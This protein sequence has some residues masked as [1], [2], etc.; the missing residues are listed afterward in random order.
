MKPK[1]L[2]EIANA[3]GRALK[4]SEIQAIEDG[5]QRHLNIVARKDVDA[6][7]KMSLHER[8]TEAAKSASEEVIANAER[9]AEN[10][11]RQIIALQRNLKIM[12]D[13]ANGQAKSKGLARLLTQV[14]TDIKGIGRDY[15][16]QMMD[17]INAAEPK[18]FEL[19]ENKAAVR[20]FLQELD[21]IKTGNEVAAKGAKAWSATAE[22]MRERFNR[23]GGDIGKLFGWKVPQPHDQARILK[24][25][26]TKWVDD[27][28][29]WLNRERYR[30]NAGRQLSDVELRQA[31]TEM[32]ETL[33][34]GGKNNMEPGQS[35]QS[36]LANRNAEHREI[37]FKDAD[38]YIA[39]MQDYGKGSIFEAMQRHVNKMARD[40]GLIEAMGPNSDRTFETLNDVTI[41]EEGKLSKTGILAVSND[42]RYKALSNFYAQA[43][44]VKLADIGS[45]IRN[46][47]SATKLQGNLLSSFADIPT[48]LM[49]AHYNNLPMAKLLLSAL[50]DMVH[51]DT[52]KLEFANRVGLVTDSVIADMNRFSGDNLAQGWTGKLANVTQK[53]SFMNRWTDSL[54]RAFSVAYMGALGKMTRGDYSALDKSD[55][56]I[57]AQHGIDEATFNV[58]KAAT[59]ENWRGSQ[60]LTPDSIRAI[61][62]VGKAE[63]DRAVTKLLGMIVDEADYAVISPDLDTRARVQSTGQRGTFNGEL[64]RAFYLFKSFPMAMASRQLTRIM[65]MDDGMAKLGYSASLIAGLTLFGAL[66]IQ[67]KDLVSGKNPRDMTGANGRNLPMLGKFWAAAFAQGGGAGI[68]GDILYTGAGGNARGGQPNWTNLAGP[69]IGTA[70][71]TANVT[72]GNVGQALG[73]QKTN[74]GAEAV[75]LAR[76][77]APFL[78]LWYAR[79][80]LD[81]AVFHEL[82]EN[83]SPGY[84]SRMRSQW[85]KDYNG[86]M[87]WEPGFNSPQKP[88]VSTALG[89]R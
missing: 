64:G 80:A 52:E 38:S 10:A 44:D 60:M 41:K 59:P 50:K 84:M 53:I 32:H 7:R 48:Y 17:A 6:F 54:K 9:K 85:A 8:L 13:L 14:D 29:P 18:F 56:S 71:D 34:T 68:F 66:S 30:D 1:C 21:G 81:H 57:F 49:T 74:F 82:Q 36:A 22:A 2:A 72:V 16:S 58:W 75:R 37:F 83:L 4:P 25:G 33:A 61:E 5:I 12:E 23:N 46:F 24:A 51:T 63:K 78:N 19:M 35:G 43:V 20:D 89:G 73:G 86:S 55:L 70:L 88:N 27:V 39:Y 69:V 26:L 77:N 65:E 3:I 11:S 45:G 42:E 87:W 40:I 67:A 79:S 62:G 28:M 31:L 76:S 47:T 15:F